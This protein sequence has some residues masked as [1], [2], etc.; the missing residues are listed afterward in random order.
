MSLF[1]A[2]FVST[3]GVLYSAPK[4]LR[5]FSLFFCTKCGCTFGLCNSHK[6]CQK[7]KKSK[8]SAPHHRGDTPKVQKDIYRYVSELP[9]ALGELPQKNA[10]LHGSVHEISVSCYQ[11][12]QRILHCRFFFETS[13]K[14]NRRKCESRDS[15]LELRK[16]NRTIM[17]FRLQNFVELRFSILRILLEIFKTLN[18]SQIIQF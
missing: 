2:R 14:E 4:G 7:H 18:T 13:E 1:F 6:N 5:T 10:H 9:A 3:S 15:K 8:R 16:G 11:E 12:N 17:M